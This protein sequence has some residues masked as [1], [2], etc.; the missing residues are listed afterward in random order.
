MCLPKGT[1]LYMEEWEPDLGFLI[2][3]VIVI[4][5]CS[6]A[7]AAGSN[8]Q[9]SC[10]RLIS[11]WTKVLLC[12]AKLAFTIHLPH[13][14]G[15]QGYRC[16][17]VYLV[18]GSVCCLAEVT[19]LYFVSHFSSPAPLKHDG[20]NTFISSWC[21]NGSVLEVRCQKAGVGETVSPRG[22]DRAHIPYSLQPGEAAAVPGE[23]SHVT[24]GF[25]PLL[26]WLHC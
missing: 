20:G 25:V 1:S 6:P 21:S 12:R 11:F 16:V 3:R 7:R 2:V 24:P 17:L 13:R 22:S 4:K 14:P 8:S 23:W 18:D 5:P 26:L 15:R 10:S 19:F 9:L